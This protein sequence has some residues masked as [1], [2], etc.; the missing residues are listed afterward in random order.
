MGTLYD[1]IVGHLCVDGMVGALTVDDLRGVD[2]EEVACASCVEN[3][4]GGGN[5]I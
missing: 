2:G 4:V 5:G 3:L 1:R